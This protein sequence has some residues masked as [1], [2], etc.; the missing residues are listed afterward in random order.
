MMSHAPSAA[1]VTATITRTTPV[2]SAP[3]PFTNALVRQPGPP[4][5]RQCTTMPAWDSVNET[6]TPIM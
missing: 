4:T 3:N 1:F 2:T 5:R 6:K